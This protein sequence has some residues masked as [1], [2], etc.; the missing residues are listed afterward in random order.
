MADF[1]IRPYRPEDRADVRHICCATGYMGQPITPFYRDEASFADMFSSYYTD[2]EPEHVLVVEHETKVVGYLFGARDARKVPDPMLYALKHVF[3]RGVCFRPGTAGF[4]WRGLR[5]VLVDLPKKHRP[6]IDY[7]RYPSNTHNNM[8]PVARGGGGRLTLECFFTLFDQL[9]QEGSTGLHGELFASNAVMMGFSMKKLKY[10]PVGDP[11]PV[12][13]IRGKQGE[14]MYGQLTVR[15][16]T[17]WEVGAW[18]EELGPRPDFRA[19][20][21]TAPQAGSDGR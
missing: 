19:V 8:L 16:L 6:K 2:S 4:Y 10:T 21:T 20:S 15:D 11:Y 13:G 12:P 17:T 7:D 5:D 18:R 14:R 9:K 3:L 1:E